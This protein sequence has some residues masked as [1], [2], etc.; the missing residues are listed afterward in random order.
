MILLYMLPTCGNTIVIYELRS[1]SICALYVVEVDDLDDPLLNSNNNVFLV[2]Q[3]R[4]TEVMTSSLTGLQTT[5][6]LN[7]DEND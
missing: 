4:V 2:V 5:W 3:R 7:K 6:T 1:W